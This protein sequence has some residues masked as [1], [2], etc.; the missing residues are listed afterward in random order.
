MI[1]LES[2]I[3]LF[4]FYVIFPYLFDYLVMFVEDVYNKGRYT[5]HE[6]IHFTPSAILYS[7]AII[8]KT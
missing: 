8:S 2:F 6:K 7:C 4:A 3:V 1:I 5:H